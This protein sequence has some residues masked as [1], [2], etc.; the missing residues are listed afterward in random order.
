MKM[1]LNLYYALFI[2]TLMLLLCNFSLCCEIGL[3][4]QLML[5]ISF[6]QIPEIKNLKPIRVSFQHFDYL[7]SQF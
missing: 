2:I 7:P 4:V 3:I 1:N 6:D 5:N